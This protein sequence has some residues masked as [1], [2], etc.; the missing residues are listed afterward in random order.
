MHWDAG[1]IPGGAFDSPTRQY[2]DLQ[3]SL[4]VRASGVDGGG[5]CIVP[6]FH[7]T[8]GSWIGSENGRKE[9]ARMSRKESAHHPEMANVSDNIQTPPGKA[10]DLLIWQNFCPRCPGAVKRH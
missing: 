7:K 1:S 4:F 10:G 2:F 6:G 8:W 9:I 3:A 5:T